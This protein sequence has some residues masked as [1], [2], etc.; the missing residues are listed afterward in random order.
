MAIAT[1]MKIVSAATAGVTVSALS[2][3]L[4]APA[5]ALGFTG[6]YAPSNFNVANDNA[7]GFVN[8]ADAP[9]SITITGG[10]T[11]S[12]LSGLTS[13]LTK[14]TGSGAINFN[15]SYSTQDWGPIYDPFG[16]ILNGTFFQLT[17]NSGSILQNGSSSFNVVLGDTFGFGIKTTDNAFGTASAT[18]S[19]FNAPVAVPSPALLP[20]LVGLGLGVL[21]KRKAEA[22]EQVS[23][24]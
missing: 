15:W 18:I 7:D 8:T 2:F 3:A 22:A 13:Y 19:S 11:Q 5:H 16:Y 24:A 21:R 17:N 9:N 20:G 10:N 23:E 12:G 1:G 4:S 14:A 6:S